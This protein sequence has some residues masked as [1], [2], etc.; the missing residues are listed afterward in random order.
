MGEA[1][2]PCVSRTPVVERR[3]STTPSPDGDGV[4]LVGI[5]LAVEGG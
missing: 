2:E 1:G 4:R 5:A 3:A